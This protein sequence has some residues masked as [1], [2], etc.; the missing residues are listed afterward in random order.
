MSEQI[1]NGETPSVSMEQRIEAIY[2]YMTRMDER[3]ER[4]EEKQR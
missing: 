4:L 1:K 2:A 3:Y